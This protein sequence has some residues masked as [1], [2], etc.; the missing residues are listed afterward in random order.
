MEESR[1]T[2]QRDPALQAILESIA[3]MSATLQQ[4]NAMLLQQRTRLEDLQATVHAAENTAATATG[5]SVGEQGQDATEASVGN[6][7]RES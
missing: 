1:E 2:N 5:A 7:L 4:Q 6:M 3:V